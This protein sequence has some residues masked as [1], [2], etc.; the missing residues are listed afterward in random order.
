MKQLKTTMFLLAFLTGCQG[1]IEFA[2]TSESDGTAPGPPS[3][4]GQTGTPDIAESCAPAER[5]PAPARRLTNEEF[6]WVVSDVL[7]VDVRAGLDAVVPDPRINGFTNDASSMSLDQRRLTAYMQAAE[8]ATAQADWGSLLETYA[9]CDRSEE[10]C[11][12]EFVVAM[13]RALWGRSPTEEEAS[14]VSTLFDGQADF[15]AAARDATVALMLHASFLYRLEGEADLT[16]EEMGTRLASALW[17]TKPD[18]WLVEQIAQG[19][20]DAEDSFEGLVDMMLADPRARR[21]TRRFATDWLD[22][23][24]LDPSKFDERIVDDALVEAMVEETVGLFERTAMEDDRD[25]MSIFSSSST[26][27]EDPR[28]GQ[29]YGFGMTEGPLDLSKTPRRGVLG[30]ASVL[31]TTGFNE[32]EVLVYRG[33]FIMKNLFCTGVPE[34]AAELLAQAETLFTDEMS[35]RERA[36]VRMTEPTCAG[37]HSA[38]EPLGFSLEIFDS[39]GRERALDAHGLS[40]QSGGHYPAH[41][42]RTFEDLNDFSN[43]LIEDPRLGTCMVQKA[44]QFSWGRPVVSEDRCIRAQIQDRFESGGRTWKALMKAIVMHPSFLTHAT[45]I[46]VAQ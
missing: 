4:P 3:T 13:G 44:M 11:R 29:L 22:L 45:T 32:E 40:V 24:V 16:H 25:L 20:L 23:D 2:H 34:P 41:P 33:L 1:Q 21:G 42:D 8:K 19:A 17:G 46:E 31:A 5:G 9:P 7:G 15:E 14:L 36:A 35:G 12:K 37:C 30:H 39:L 43:M 27:V 38:F 18:A 26:R 6:A 28:L 10:A